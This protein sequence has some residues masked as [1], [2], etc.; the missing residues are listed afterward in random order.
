[1]KGKKGSMQGH[2]DRNRCIHEFLDRVLEVNNICAIV[3]DQE[4]R[5]ERSASKG[6]LGPNGRHYVSLSLKQM[7]LLWKIVHYV[8]TECCLRQLEETAGLEYTI[9]STKWTKQDHQH[10][11]RDHPPRPLARPS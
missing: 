11:V 5:A 3:T 4:R 8:H 10:W 1:M 2:F 9:R 7:T 6:S